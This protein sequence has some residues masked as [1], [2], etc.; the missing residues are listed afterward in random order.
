MTDTWR[1]FTIRRTVGGD[2]VRATTGWQGAL[3]YGPEDV[4]FDVAS[5]TTLQAIPL[6]YDTM[7]ITVL[8]PVLS[9]NCA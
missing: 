7:Q 3:R 8:I 2:V 4:P 1:P 9:I 5:V 6:G